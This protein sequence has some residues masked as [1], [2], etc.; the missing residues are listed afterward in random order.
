MYDM[1][2]NFRQSEIVKHRNEHLSSRNEHLSSIPIQNSLPVHYGTPGKVLPPKQ[3]N[4][5][6]Q[7]S[8]QQTFPGNDNESSLM[9]QVLKI[10]VNQ[11][12][13]TK[14]LAGYKMP[15]FNILECNIIYKEYFNIIEK[16]T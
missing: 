11:D 15:I 7:G 8:L 1:F 14:S 3:N 5:L 13:K 9:F 12:L 6:I 4:G 2:K 16:T 10:N